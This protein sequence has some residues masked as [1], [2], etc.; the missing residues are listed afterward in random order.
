MKGEVK[1]TGVDG[2][3]GM[4]RSLPAEVV[5]KNG[6]PVK[7]AL[8]KAARVIQQQAVSNLRI[9]TE[10]QTES[11]Q[12]ESTGLLAQNVVVTRGKAP[13]SDKGE[14]YLVRVRRK[15]YGRKGKPVN[16]QQT[17]QRLEYGTSKQPA[18]P[19]LRPAFENKAVEAIRT[20]ESELLK[21]IDRA[22]KKLA[23]GK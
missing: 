13:T 2:V 21:G 18:E 16:T 14:R 19:W 20:A 15:S 4:L 23:K 17:G 8:R 11:G 1:L 9:V 5:S 6:G 12:K 3:I 10:N 22:V 7:S